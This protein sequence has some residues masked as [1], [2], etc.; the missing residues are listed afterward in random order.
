MN[1]NIEI[2][3]TQIEGPYI[4]RVI[5]DKVYTVKIHFSKTN[6]ETAQDKIRRMVIRDVENEHRYGRLGL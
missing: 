1:D 5:G 4:Q 6:K 3:K 2:K